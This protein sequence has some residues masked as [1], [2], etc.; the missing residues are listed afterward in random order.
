[1]IARVAGSGERISTYTVSDTEMAA[2]STLGAPKG[3]IEL[4]ANGAIKKFYSADAGSVLISG[5]Q[6]AFFDHRTGVILGK[7]PGNFVIHPDRQEH[8]YELINGLVVHEAV[9][10]L[11]GPPDLARVDPLVAYFDVTLENRSKNDASVDVLAAAQMRGGTPA[12]VRFRY[13]DNRNALIAWNQS[14]RGWVRSISSTRRPTS[15]EVTSDHAKCSRPNFAGPLSGTIAK[16]AEEP[17]GMLHHRVTIKAGAKLRLCYVLSGTADGARDHN[18]IL[19]SLRSYDEAEAWTRRRYHEI[20]NRAVVMTPDAEVNRGVLWAKANMLRTMLYTQTGW[21]FVNDP[22][23]SNN[24]VCRDTSWFAVGSDY[25]TPDF[26]RE[27]LL[28]YINHLE[29]SGMAIEYYDIRNG[30]SAD[31]HLNINDNTPLL[32]LALWHH[33]NATGDRAFLEEVYGKAKRAAEYILSQRNKNGLVWCTSTGVSDW[34]IVGWRNVIAGYRLSGATTEVNSECYAALDAVGKMARKLSK[35]KDADF[36]AREAQALRKAINTHLLDP[37]TGLYYLNIDV[38]GTARTDV[39]ADMVFPVMFGVADHETAAHIISRLSME[40]FWTDAGIRTVPSNDIN[41]GPTHGYGLLGGV[42]VGV[43]FWYAFAA[44]KFNPQFMATAL[45][46]SFRHYS[47]DPGRNNTVP[48]QFSEW[49]HGDTLTNQGMMLSPWFPPRYLWAAIEGAGG[50]DL[51]GDTPSCN[52]KLAPDWRWMAVRRVRYQGG[53]VSW[54]VARMGEPVMYASFRFEHSSE[55]HAFDEDVT[56]DL[57]QGLNDD[58]TGLVL[59]KEDELVIFVGNTAERAVMAPLALSKELEG[60]YSM[61]SFSS[62]RGEWVD[63]GRLTGK[64]LTKGFAVQIDRKGFCVFELR[65]HAGEAR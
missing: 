57:L 7:L 27:S 25:V 2:G 18:R 10:V 47:S 11:S 30:K 53:F 28:W 46:N 5:F 21:G 48:G 14:Q 34:G 39:T 41:Y 56:E 49:L 32:L 61:R 44:A 64:T 12:D 6:V 37:E 38:D 20:L 45:S 8:V 65:R 42:W 15:F 1:M 33:Y 62:M 55:Y 54:F 35:A 50:L 22:T 31:Y 19:A 4:K 40:P 9:L 29:K 52:P 51:S 24:S 60:Q 23:R 3:A 59:R 26:S 16:K 63:E 36:F 17:I 13:D 43:S 58:V